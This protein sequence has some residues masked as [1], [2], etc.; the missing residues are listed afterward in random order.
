[1]H[2]LGP[3][4]KETHGWQCHPAVP[5]TCHGTQRAQH[6]YIRDHPLHH[7]KEPLY[8]LLKV[9]SSIKPHWALWVCSTPENSLKVGSAFV[10]SPRAG[11]EPQLVKSWA[12]WLQDRDCLA[13]P[14]A[15]PDPTLAALSWVAVKELKLSYHNMDMY[16]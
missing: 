9:Y 8:V 11:S 13:R 16:Q 15:S 7:V 10:L 12:L 3:G 2:V 4:G 6:G 14:K 1:M 5:H